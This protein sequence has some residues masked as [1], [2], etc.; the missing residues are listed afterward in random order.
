MMIESESFSFGILR[1]YME[2][3]QCPRALTCILLFFCYDFSIFLSI[4]HMS[5][6]DEF[7]AF[8]MRGNVVDLAV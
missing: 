5:F 6:I 7:K 2:R 4:F 3:Y 1:A 8:A